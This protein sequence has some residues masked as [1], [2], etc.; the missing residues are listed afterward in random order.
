MTAIETFSEDVTVAS[1]VLNGTKGSSELVNA[2]TQVDV[3]RSITQASTLTID[4]D[5]P[6][7][8]LLVSP[9]LTV[10]SICQIDGLS[11]T[12]AAIDKRADQLSLTFESSTIQR[13]RTTTGALSVAAGQGTRT[14]FAQRLVASAAGA[15]IPF[16]GWPKASPIAETLTR[17]TS[18]TPNEDT[19]TALTRLASEV[20]WRCFEVAG[21]IWFG[22]DSWLL[23]QAPLGTLNEFADGVQ[24]I[25][26]TFDVG[27]PLST[28]TVTVVASRWAFPPGQIVTLAG[29]GPGNGP[30]IISAAARTLYQPLATITLTQ[31]QAALPEPVAQTTTTDPSGATAGA[32]V[33]G[34]S[35]K[36]QQA[37]AFA[38]SQLGLPY[39]YGGESPGR[40]F[41]CS[42]L[43]QSSYSHVGI[44]IPRVAQD[45]WNSGPKV[46][47]PLQP[48]DL[49]FFGTG[50]GGVSHVGMYLGGG[51]MID[52][53]HTG[54]N[55]R[56]E[57]CP[58]VGGQHWGSDVFVGATRPAP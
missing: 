38:K 4:L 10:A 23:T 34:G 20:Q 16:H 13:L 51:Q 35:A 54:A 24:F 57:A 31:P 46:A 53:P 55:V 28:A 33:A 39:T 11:F 44:S 40:T 26:F 14:E 15:K 32:G 12:L 17:G 30:W 58:T 41:D 1:L 3:A 2:V 52:A 48:G 6:L 37:I 7:R 36:A 25:D 22:P 42:G 18:Q 45:Q 49:M 27:Q 29:V 56:I 5:D 19:W 50:P 47:G 9:I 21:E 8:A 43:T